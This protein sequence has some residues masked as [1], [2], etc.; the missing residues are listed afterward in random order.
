MFVAFVCGL[1]LVACGSGGGTAVTP[2]PS[3]TPSPLP[4]PSA[5]STKDMKISIDST[6]HKTAKVGT[7]TTFD[8][9][10]Q[11]VGTADIP[12]LYLAF[13]LGDRFLD[14][15]SI[16]S[17]GPC[18][19]DSNVPGLACGRLVSLGSHLMF[20]IKATPKTAGSFVFKFTVNQYKTILSQAD[21]DQYDYTWTQTISS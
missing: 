3:P 7:S 16:Q 20:T 13:N 14:N 18:Q 10:I 11:D 12:N 21:G 19:V 15:Y 17:S 9:D 6:Y 2:T 4:T 8:V 1:L 5:V